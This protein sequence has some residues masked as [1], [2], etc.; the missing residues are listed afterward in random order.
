MIKDHVHC[1]TKPN[2]ENDTIFTIV[3]VGSLNKNTPYNALTVGVYAS[4]MLA[5]ATEFK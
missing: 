2:G 3:D 4:P 5:G 1:K